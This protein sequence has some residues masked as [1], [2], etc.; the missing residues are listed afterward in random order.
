MSWITE[1]KACFS[2]G[3]CPECKTKLSCPSGE[4]EVTDLFI[5][6]CPKCEVVW[7][8]DINWGGWTQGFIKYNPALDEQHMFYYREFVPRKEE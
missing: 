8:K 3:F 4:K 6:V 1:W 7:Y 2:E 5:G